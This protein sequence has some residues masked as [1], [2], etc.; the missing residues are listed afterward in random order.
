[1]NTTTTTA[2]TTT[3]TMV[4]F[5]TPHANL[6]PLRFIVYTL[7]SHDSSPCKQLAN[8]TPPPSHHIRLLR[9][10][11]AASACASASPGSSFELMSSKVSAWS[12]CKAAADANAVASA[13]TAVAASVY[14][15]W[16]AGGGCCCDGVCDVVAVVIGW[17]L[18]LTNAAQLLWRWSR[19]IFP[20]GSFWWC[21]SEMMV[22]V[23][24]VVVVLMME[25]VMM[26]ENSS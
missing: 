8:G 2:A 17:F 6:F 12:G 1:M 16:A 18:F 23:L 13:A 3:T 7:T 21:R 25:V 22:V 9:T 26:G 5:N 10:A 14:T 19:C 11:H 24:V 15:S 4:I 20:G